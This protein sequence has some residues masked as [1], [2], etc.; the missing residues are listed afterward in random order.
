MN[1]CAKVANRIAM[2]C[3]NF[4]FN[5]LSR[6]AEEIYN[7]ASEIVIK[8]DI[9]Y[10]FTSLLDLP[11]D[12]LYISEDIL[13]LLLGYKGNLLDALCDIYITKDCQFYEDIISV[14]EIL[15]ESIKNKE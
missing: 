9:D 10:F 6:G 3:T 12:N 15:A 1:I 14:V 7:N 4:R 2:E 8:N 13:K 11:E 5:M